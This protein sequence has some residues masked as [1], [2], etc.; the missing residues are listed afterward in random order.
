[1]GGR[2][3]F[4]RFRGGAAW[5]QSKGKG[6]G[7]RRT[8][9]FMGRFGGRFKGA[10]GKARGGL[11][12]TFAGLKKRLPKNMHDAVDKAAKAADAQVQG[13][14]DAGQVAAAEEK[15]AEEVREADPVAGK[16]IDNDNG[17]PAAIE[18]ATGEPVVGQEMPA[19]QKGEV[20]AP[21]VATPGA[22]AAQEAE[23][24]PAQTEEQ[25]GQ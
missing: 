5:L 14:E 3:V 2:G 17:A 6:N 15:V 12:N 8:G 23:S 20:E 7:L 19:E 4:N 1:M 16:A 18:P 11:K 10:M 21:A 9:A 24:A 25:P 22:N 13:A